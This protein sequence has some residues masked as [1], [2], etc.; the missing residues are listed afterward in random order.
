MNNKKF[1]I[2][3]NLHFENDIMNIEVDGIRHTFNLKKIS[4]LLLNASWIERNAFKIHESGYGIHWPLI[5]EDLS[6][7]GLLAV[8]SKQHQ[9]A[10]RKHSKRNKSGEKST[11]QFI[12][13]EKGTRYSGKKD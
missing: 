9:S 11:E 4:K 12:V 5:D 2:I 7:D 13:K 1:H 10:K 6:I 3:K 8:K